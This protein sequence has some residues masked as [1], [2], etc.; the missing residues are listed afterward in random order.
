MLQQ[1]RP[2]PGPCRDGQ[3]RSPESVASKEA[4]ETDTQTEEKQ[5]LIS[6]T[7]CSTGTCAL[8][9]ASTSPSC[10]CLGLGEVDQEAH[11][12]PPNEQ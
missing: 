11:L 7:R 1:R 2:S 12:E 4:H 8:P 6:R 5:N 10:I 9:S 3:L